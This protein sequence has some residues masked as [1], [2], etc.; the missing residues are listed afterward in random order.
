[1]GLSAYLASLLPHTYTKVMLHGKRSVRSTQKLF[2]E[3]T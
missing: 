1:M 3:Y 2:Y